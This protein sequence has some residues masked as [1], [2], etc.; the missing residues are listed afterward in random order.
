MSL[1]IIKNRKFPSIHN[2]HKLM[3]DFVLENQ[4]EDVIYALA[5]S[6]HFATNKLC[7]AARQSGLWM[8]QDG[9]LTWRSAFA[10]LE[11]PSLPTATAVAVASDD[12]VF[13]GVPGALLS[14]TDGG[15]SWSTS[16]LPTPS[17]FITT[18]A[19]SP[20]YPQDGMALAG[21][22]EDGVFVSDDY[23]NTWNAWN[24]GLLDQ[25]IF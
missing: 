6:A 8:S 16:V 4:S 5:A 17:P 20:D 13:V 12:T 24:F 7:Y 18:I 15:Q 2:K 23:G 10:S 19:V 3:N 22:M 1:S 14:S 9:G 21:S 25:N 11:L